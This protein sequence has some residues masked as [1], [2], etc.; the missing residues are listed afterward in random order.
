MRIVSRR[1]W[2]ARQARRR[3]PLNPARVRGVAVHHTVTG[4]YGD[5]GSIL[6]GIQ[7]FHMD[8]KRWNDIA[9]NWL[10]DLEGNTYE[11][12]GLDTRGAA[13]KDNNSRW[14]SIAFIGDFRRHKL[15][16]AAI[17]SFQRIRCDFFLPRYPEAL[18]VRPHSHF[19]STECPT[20]EVRQFLPQLS[21]ECPKQPPPK[22]QIQPLPTWYQISQLLGGAPCDPIE[23]MYWQILGRAPDL[24]GYKYWEEKG[25]ELGIQRAAQLMANTEEAEAAGFSWD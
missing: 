12:R 25:D 16:R 3:T 4:A 9:Y 18:A 14:V 5:T 17:E 11:G 13:T 1:S 19:V 21:T 15:T 7:N 10:I 2:D 20:S 22:A 8:T 23:Q 6:R 24:A